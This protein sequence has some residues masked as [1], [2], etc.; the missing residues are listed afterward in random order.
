MSLCADKIATLFRK[1]RL[2]IN[3][4]ELI[5]KSDNPTNHCK[6]VKDCHPVNLQ[7]E[8]GYLAL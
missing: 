1:D 7:I 5:V 6:K 8:G 4:R 3:T 2:M